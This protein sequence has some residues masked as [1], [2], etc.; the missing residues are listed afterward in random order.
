MA[1]ATS[2]RTKAMRFMLMLPAR[3]H[4]AGILYLGS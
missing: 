2:A 4:L 1:A 3:R